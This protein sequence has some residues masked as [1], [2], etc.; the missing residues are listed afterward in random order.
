MFQP[1]HILYIT[2]EKDQHALD[3]P[4][5]SRSNSKNCKIFRL[6]VGRKVP[7]KVAANEL[8]TLRTI[9]YFLRDSEYIRNEFKMEKSSS[10]S[11][12]SYSPPVHVRNG[13]IVDSRGIIATALLKAPSLK[14]SLSSVSLRSLTRAISPRLV[15]ALFN[16]SLVGVH[17][18]DMST[19]NESKRNTMMRL[20]YP[21][22]VGEVNV[23]C[24]FDNKGL[25]HRVPSN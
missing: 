17:I 4:V 16:C 11:S 22:A 6:E 20:K 8:R 3:I 18:S 25:L 12:S 14:A 13:S 15:L 19:D 1:T 23:L 7:S 10:S 9:S 24:D 5:F 2:S 21:S